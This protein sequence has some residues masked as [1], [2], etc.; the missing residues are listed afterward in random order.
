MSD[1]DVTEFV[2]FCRNFDQAMLVTNSDRGLIA[3]P[4]IIAEIDSHGD[5]WFST[6]VA[7]GKVVE[8][9][10]NPDVCI[11]MTN[12]SGNATVRGTASI[13]KDTVKIKELWNE[14]WRVWFPAG[15]TDP[16]LVLIKVDTS[17]GEFWATGGIQGWKYLFAMAKSYVR[18]ER[19]KDD[20]NVHRVVEL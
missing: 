2:S 3:R 19:P 11:T 18:G 16:K 9:D 4:M 1:H 5:F 13:V 10:N 20:I 7:S 12:A 15:P 6:D 14:T 8:I 17:E